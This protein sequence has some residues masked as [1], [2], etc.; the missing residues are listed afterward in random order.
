VVIAGTGLV[1]R[2]V[3]TAFVVF[4]LAFIALGWQ[5]MPSQKSIEILPWVL[6]ALCRRAGLAAIRDL[7]G[8]YPTATIATVVL[9]TL[10]F[11]ND[12]MHGFTKTGMRQWLAS[13]V[14][15]PIGALA[16]VTLRVRGNAVAEFA[17]GYAT[18]LALAA[19]VIIV[20]RVVLGQE[21]PLG[22]NHN[23][24]S[25][26][27]ALV[28][29]GIVYML[30]HQSSMLEEDSRQRMSARLLAVASVATVFVIV[31]SGARSPLIAFAA[32]ALF[33]IALFAHRL[34]FVAFIAIALV[35]IIIAASGYSRFVQIAG[36]FAAYLGGNHTT[37]VGGRLDAWRWFGEFG[38]DSPWIG[39]SADAVR[40]SLS[41]RGHLWNLGNQAL[42]DMWHLHCDLLQ[43]TAAYGV[44]AAL[45]YVALMIGFSWRALSTIIRRRDTSSFQALATPAMTVAIVL[46]V[47][48]AGLT[49]SMTYWA[50]VWLA[51]SGAVALLLALETH[52]SAK[53]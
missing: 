29:L 31:L 43:L 45:A 52:L 11:S 23:V 19:V 49:D 14:W 32:T 53:A 25:G 39:Q 15:L 20:Q 51:W 35:A 42:P 36:E 48:I 27:L 17:W 47:V 16:L 26:S 40:E 38:L 24:L 5:D 37:S 13:I 30:T 6:L 4:V 12:A 46:V 3:F 41:Q 21:R 34:R 10:I 2:P 50:G 8:R 22:L 33:L 44:F 1:A 28:T 18:G 9:A 7:V